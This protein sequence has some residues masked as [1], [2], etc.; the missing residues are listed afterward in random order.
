MDEK[1]FELGH[2]PNKQNNPNWAR[3]IEEVDKY[4]MDKHPSKLMVMAAISYWTKSDLFFYV[5][6]G[7]YVK[8]TSRKQKQRHSLCVLKY[9]QK[10]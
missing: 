3:S 4:P 7:E 5:I 9:L 6:E 2:P 1:P 10:Q 8:G